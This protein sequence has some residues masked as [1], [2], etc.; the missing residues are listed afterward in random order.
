MRTRFVSP[1]LLLLS[2]AASGNPWPEF[3]GPNRS[4]TESQATFPIHFG[5]NSNLVWRV[6]VP[7]GSSSPI[8]W[9]RYLVLTAYASNQLLTLAFDAASGQRLWQAAV[10]PGTIETGS[11][12]SHPASATPCTD[13]ERWISYFA[14]F[15]IVAYE[16]SGAELWR[17]PL[18]TPITGHGASSSPL[19]AG[20]L[21][22]QLCDQDFGSYLLAL[23]KHTGRVRWRAE[24]PDFRRS[25]STPLL[26]PPNKPEIAVVAGTLKLAAYALS[27]GSE[28]WRVSGLPNEL[29]A[30]PIAADQLIFTAG[31]TPG[32]GVPRM[33][34]WTNLMSASDLNRDQALSRDEAPAGPA[35]Q[36]F[37]YID[38][39]RDGA[40][41]EVEYRTI[42][43]I[44]DAS[45]NNAL[46]VRPGGTG[47]VTQTH[48]AWA[49]SRG[50]PYV[51][52]PIC[53]DGRLFM[54]RNGGLASCLDAA[55]GR[56]FYQ[57]ERL[58][59]LGD[60]Y[61]SP[62]GADRKILAISHSGVAVVVKL[63]DTLE[64]LAR[65]TLGDEVVSTPALS[66]DTLYIRTQKALFAFRESPNILKT[67][68]AIS[69]P[70]P[71]D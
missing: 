16:S 61:A 40:L 38:A 5:P 8:L 70:L 46:A 19:L 28:R 25:F 52:T 24:R 37:H 63:G 56:Y 32:S 26:W 48:V 31:W 34:A 47:D 20:D 55:T 49:Q 30:S 66:G 69:L 13:G 10:D 58:G 71:Q 51:P 4:G 54:V 53:L 9:G 11:R 15:G 68:P 6:P 14:P 42:A 22:L 57:E 27:T 29:V 2:L 1:L 21:L 39:N 50:L 3:R 36:H 33:P 62:I 12:L 45:R 43:G 65:N 60:Y 64:V 41:S 17:H 67:A 35:K 18:P 7:P 23:D 44:F 59:A